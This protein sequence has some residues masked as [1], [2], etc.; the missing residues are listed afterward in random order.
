[1]GLLHSSPIFKVLFAALLLWPTYS[2]AATK[3][4]YTFPNSAR[5]PPP[6]K[7]LPTSPG[8]EIPHQQTSTSWQVTAK[9]DGIATGNAAG[10]PAYLYSPT[11]GLSFIGFV[12]E[13][14]AIKLE[15]VEVFNRVHFY[16]MPRPTNL[17]ADESKAK[18]KTPTTKAVGKSD[19]VWIPGLHIVE[20]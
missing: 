18:E 7:R 13:G 2:Y 15:H 3:T 9:K 4:W 14:T 16:G 10:A 19:L 17:I 11:Y 12:P 5:V 1:M 20:K 6:S 8:Y